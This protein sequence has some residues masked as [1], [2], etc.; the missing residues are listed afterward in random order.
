MNNI[1]IKISFWTELWSD[2]I[3]N[4][5]KKSFGLT[6]YNP[7]ILIDDI[8]TEIEENGFKN[9][10]N[11]KYFYSKLSEYI[12]NDPIINKKIKSKFKILRKVFNTERTGYILESCKEI[13]ELFQNGFYFDC[14]IELVLDLFNRD[15][16]ISLEFVKT[17]NYLTQSIIVELIKKTYDIEE[18][19]KFLN[20]IFDRYTI[21]NENIL[22]TNFPHE[23][24][25]ENYVNENDQFNRDEYNK[26]VITLITS[27]TLNDRIKKLSYYYH[28]KKE[29]VF[30][31][32]VV[33]GLKGEIEYNFGGVTFYS[34]DKKQ[35][36]KEK[37]D[38]N[39]E[40]LQRNLGTKKYIQAAVEVDYLLPLTSKREAITKLENALDLISCYF[41]TKTSLYLNDSNYTIINEKGRIISS[42][43]SR[44]KRDL[45]IKFEDSLDLFEREKQLKELKEK[46]F[47]W[48][49]NRKDRKSSLKILNALHWY[50]KAEDSNK[51]ED[52]IL[53][54][55]IS[56][57]NLFN[58]ERD[59]NIDVLNDRHKNKLQLI[60]ETIASLQIFAFVYEFGWELY[61]YYYSIVNN[62][63]VIESP[64]PDVLVQKAQ[65]KPN[66][67]EKVYLKYFVDSLD[68]IRNY[69]KNLFIIDKINTIKEFYT[70]PSQTRKI[71]EEQILHVKND[72]LMVYRFRNLI[73]HNAHFD[74]TLLPYYVWKIR[75][76]AGKLIRKVI[77]DFER[78]IELPDI[79]IRLH[80]SKE[81]FLCEFELGNVNLF[82]D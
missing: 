81:E 10:D 73:V 46:T 39:F 31:I 76:F 5:L 34:L 6:L 48:N 52:K 42:S 72:V 33:E 27:L 3:D 71:V 20:N 18:I 69:E 64:L 58:L 25:P 51:Y 38:F 12:A 59:I 36:A 11:K 40:D 43:V 45:L 41:S 26:D 74:N 28:K 2:L 70:N 47:I 9:P 78:D 75:N 57:E 66:K 55:W 1:E 24:D 50:R 37:S 21:S 49:D 23:I 13:K 35:F 79:F 17:L 32:F 61:Y 63:F 80:L 19:K 30:Y 60:Q 56:I 77:A 15:E 16:N 7:Q 68:E 65:L 67:N 82:K 44:D 29:K 8:I 54:Y 4:F 14:T 62:P 22:F 53:N